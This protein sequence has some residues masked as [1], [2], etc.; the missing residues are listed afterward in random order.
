MV[1]IIPELLIASADP[2]RQ[3]TSLPGKHVGTCFAVPQPVPVIVTEL[4]QH[5]EKCPEV[6]RFRD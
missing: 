3:F 5:V 6:L 2:C 1:R 4:R